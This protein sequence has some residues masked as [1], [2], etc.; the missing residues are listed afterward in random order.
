MSQK[1]ETFPV[2]KSDE[3]WRKELDAQQYQVLR[4]HATERAGTS[5][6]NAEKR[7]GEFRCAGCGEPLF[8]SAT[9]YESGSGWPSFWEPRPGAVGTTTDRSFFMTRTEVHCAKCGGHLGHVFPDGPQPTGQRYCMN[10]AAMKF[11]EK[12]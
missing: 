8:D 12:K 6:L 9:K 5:P 3:E 2:Q 1:T 10:G 4:K 7:K 11:E